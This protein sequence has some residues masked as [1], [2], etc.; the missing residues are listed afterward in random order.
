MVHVVILALE[1]AVPS[2]VLMAHD[3]FRMAEFTREPG[4]GPLFSV[5]IV[6]ENGRAV[7]RSPVVE[8]KAQGSISH[9]N[10]ADVVLIPSGGY[11]LKGL[12]SFSP[13]LIRWIRSM[14]DKGTD[15]AGGCTGVFLLAEAGLLSG[16]KATTHWAFADLFRMRFP[17][18]NLVDEE[19]L[20]HDGGV[21]CSGGGTAGM[22]LL[23]YLIEKY[24]GPECAKRCSAL[25]L[26]DRGRDAQTPYK[27]ALFDKG[28][29]DMP[30]L[31]A[32]TFMEQNIGSNL[33]LSDVADHVGMSLRNFKRRFKIATGDSPL[34]YLQRLRMEK[35]KRILENRRTR[36]EDLA[37]RVGYEDLGFFRKL[38]VRYTG[39]S[40]SDYGKRFRSRYDRR[41]LRAE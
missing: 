41:E 12:S 7:K 11:S 38:F 35:A 1:H 13:K 16:K 17:D 24:Q 30:I 29:T 40:P 21:Y 26:L 9:V 14:H 31:K 33:L 4:A 27:E 32:Q 39:V 37:A 18:V 15:L 23:L 6:T 28:H 25:M 5:R 36:I 22:D 3:L 19:I 2:G 10:Q 34:M 20:T 8:I